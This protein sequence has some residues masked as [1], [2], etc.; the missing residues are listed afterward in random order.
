MKHQVTNK[1]EETCLWVQGSKA[2]SSPLN[3]REGEGILEDSRP[4]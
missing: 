4:S 3:G 1:L 2:S